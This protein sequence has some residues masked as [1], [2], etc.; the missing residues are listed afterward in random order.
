MEENSGSFPIPNYLE[1]IR[2]R[3]AKRIE[4]RRKLLQNAE[5]LVRK[6]EKGPDRICKVCNFFKVKRSSKNNTRPLDKCWRCYLGR[7]VNRRRVCLRC[8]SRMVNPPKRVCWICLAPERKLA[9]R[10]QAKEN[11]GI[12]KTRWCKYKAMG[13]SGY[14]I[15]HTSKSINDR[16][17]R[18]DDALPGGE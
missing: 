3:E 9:Q 13:K 2:Q 17:N 6:A 12:C 14:C 15:R 8:G 11:R 16:D 18:R 5:S 1:V 4:E 10:A 7:D